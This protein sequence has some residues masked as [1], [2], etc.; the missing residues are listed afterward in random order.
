MY[1]SINE[2]DEEMKAIFPRPMKAGRNGEAGKSRN[3]V[4]GFSFIDKKLST[5]NEK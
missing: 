3:V 5:T 1:R 2:S 4:D